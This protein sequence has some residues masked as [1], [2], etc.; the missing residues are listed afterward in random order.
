MGGWQCG[1]C[2]GDN[3]DGTRYCGWCGIERAALDTEA[4]RPDERRLVTALFADISG[5]TTLSEQIDD[6]E[7]LHEVIAPVISGMAAIAERYD[8]TIAKYAGDALLVFFGAPV[9]HEDDATR[10][11]LVALEMHATL[12]DLLMTLPEE[13]RGLELHIGV[14]TGRVIS[15]QFGGD[16]RNDYSILGDAVILA[17]RLES[18][19]PNGEVYVGESTVELTRS[20]FDFESVGDLQL[21]GK[22]KPVAAWRL[23]GRRSTIPTEARVGPLIGRVHEL[24]AIDGMLI[25]LRRGRGAGVVTVLGDP[26]V[27]KSRLL[28]EAKA[29]AEEREVRWIQVRCPSY[30][31]TLPYWPYAELVRALTGVRVEH[32]T[33][34]ARRRLSATVTPALVPALARLIGVGEPNDELADLDPESLRER[35]HRAVVD[36]LIGLAERTPMV[37]AIEDVHWIDS[38]SAALS[39]ELARVT[40]GWPMALVLTSRPEGV[41]TLEAA[42]ACVDHQWTAHFDITP[43]DHDAILV[44]VTSLLDGEPPRELI[45]VIENRTGGNP[46]FVGELVHHLLDEGAL[47]TVNGRWRVRPGWSTDNV[48]DTVE[49]VLSA[50]IDLLAPELSTALQTASVIGRLVRLPILHALDTATDDL[51]GALSRLVEAGFLDPVQDGD[52]PALVFHHALVQE[53]AYG[54]LLRRHRRDLHRQVAEVAEALYGAGDDVID[55]L[56]RHSYLGERGAIAAGYLVRAGN[57][58]R[59]LYANEE[60]ILHLERARELARFAPETADD[61]KQVLL[62]L[63][64]LRNVTGDYDAALDL[65]AESVDVQPDIRAWLG[66][67]DVHRKR[68]EFAQVLDVV[69]QGFDVHG[70]SAPGVACLWHQKG[71]TLLLQ[72][73]TA[74][75]IGALEQGVLVASSDDPIVGQ[76]VVT[77]ARACA[78]ENRA[79]DALQY[80]LLARQS[81]ERHRDLRGLTGAL[82]VI[83][84][85]YFVME[86]YDE[87]AEEFRRALHM[88]E[89]TGTIEELA[90]GLLN[91][92]M[93]ELR[94]GDVDAAIECDRRAIVEFERIGHTTGQANAYCNVAE[95]LLRAS[96]LDEA[97]DYCLRALDHAHA[98]GLPIT[99]ADVTITMAEVREQQGRLLDAVELADQAAERFADLGFDEDAEAARTFASR[100]R[101]ALPV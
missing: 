5:F 1:R 75:A 58:A 56:A 76:L 23:V 42:R 50:R 101:A 69:E 62:D 8:G 45:R 20:S 19:A 55:L 18:V 61:L 36:W 15:G 83:G 85:A 33:G 93:T 24:S 100:V 28:V 7:E 3:P 81:F 27:G 34:K 60:A 72:G 65:Y 38:G 59:R 71:W 29:R 10:A 37:V 86:R 25:G 17:Q 32:S 44:Y 70:R 13:A 78:L 95:K 79:E 41:T 16:I 54:R 21:K 22:S 98:V 35:L 87:A 40:Q 26:G 30:G 68:G 67:A 46:L 6:P 39:E 51:D 52:D 2:Q 11:L 77:L 92:G 66:R 53:V 82:R 31:E 73:D 74:A 91:L 49:R 4:D 47:T 9:A 90:G 63:A 89:R 84:H 96:R 48:P 14:N 12:P 43:L 80:G 88:A 97:T 57:R 99:V 64:D 94:R